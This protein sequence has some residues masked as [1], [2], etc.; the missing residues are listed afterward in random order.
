MDID[1]RTVQLFLGEE[2]VSEVSIASHNPKKVRCTC[3]SFFNAARCKHTKYVKQRM[4][5]NGG[6]YSIS[7]PEEI[8]DNEAYDAM[9][10]SD[11]FREFVIRYGA[12]EVID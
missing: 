2:G 5:E 6:S 10:D 8:D 4:Q 9:I 7:I 3:A 1:W 12:V 11:T